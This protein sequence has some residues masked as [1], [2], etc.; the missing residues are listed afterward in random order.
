MGSWS[1]SGAWDFFG[2]AVLGQFEEREDSAL[3]SAVLIPGL[4]IAPS[5]PVAL[6]RYQGLCISF[7]ACEMQVAAPPLQRWEVS[8]KQ[9][10][11]SCLLLSTREC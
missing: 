9:R 4:A 6:S 5:G 10:V 7:H 2:L 1:I 11:W 8:V 3:R